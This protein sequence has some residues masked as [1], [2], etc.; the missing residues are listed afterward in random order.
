MYPYTRV[1]VS[2]RFISLHLRSFWNHHVEIA[3]H[4]RTEQEGKFGL[5]LT[6]PLLGGGPLTLGRGLDTLV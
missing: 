2:C 5:W 1:S 4:Q 6:D 3:N